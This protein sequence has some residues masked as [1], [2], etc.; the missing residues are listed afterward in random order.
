VTWRDLAACHPRNKPEDVELHA[1]V[2]QFF[3][4]R[5]QSHRPAQAICAS[6]PVSEQCDAE[7]MT[8]PYAHRDGI[9]GGKTG[10]QRRRLRFGGTYDRGYPRETVERALTLLDDG[11]T[12]AEVSGRVGA[13]KVTI[14]NWRNAA[15]SAAA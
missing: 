1:W 10:R 12:L 7:A 2:A 15:R 11:L 14:R 4:E 5:G 8:Q 6:C 9:W 3:P 13:S